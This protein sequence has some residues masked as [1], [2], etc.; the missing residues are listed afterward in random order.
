MATTWAMDII[1]TRTFS[2]H[3]RSTTSTGCFCTS[4]SRI[5]PSTRLCGVKTRWPRSSTARTTRPGAPAPVP[6]KQ[7][8]QLCSASRKCMKEN[9]TSRTRTRTAPLPRPFSAGCLRPAETKLRRPRPRP[10][11]P[12]RRCARAARDSRAAQ[13]S[14][15]R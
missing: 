5:S 4:R 15:C 10:R 3:T 6:E 12:R 9:S 2:G 14:T 7:Q 8:C 13:R 1:L 11:R